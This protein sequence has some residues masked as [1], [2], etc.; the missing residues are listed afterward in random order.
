MT[1]EEKIAFVTGGAAAPGYGTG[2]SDD[3]TGIPR[4]GIPPFRA[5]DSGLGIAAGGTPSTA[6]PAGLSAPSRSRGIAPG[7]LRGFA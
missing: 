4:L 3:R 2:G 7:G 5:S 1:L 6:F